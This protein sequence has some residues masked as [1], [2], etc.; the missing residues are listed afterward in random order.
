MDDRAFLILRRWPHHATHSGY[1]I[2]ARHV[3]TPLSADPIPKWLLPDRLLW[4]LARGVIPYD[5][6]AVALELLGARHMLTHRDAVYHFLYAESSYKYLG[7]LNGKRGHHLL[8]TFHVPPGGF[9]EIIQTSEHIKRLSGAII[10]GRNQYAMLDHALPPERIWFVPYAVD[11]EYFRP[12]DKHDA[13]T[14]VPN[15][16]TTR[17]ESTVLFVGHHLRDF[18]VLRAVIEQAGLVAPQLKFVVVTLP[19]CF[20]HFANLKG[21]FELYSGLP[22]A[23]LLRLYQQ[24]ILMAL[25]LTDAVANTA[26]LEAMACG[27]PMVITDV[28]AVRDYVDESHAL[29]VPK[30][31]PGAML[32]AILQLYAARDARERMGKSARQRA[33]LFDWHIIADQVRRIYQS[34][35]G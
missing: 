31:E 3:G 21:N 6:T 18:Q 16:P 22:E 28:G 35:R 11:T 1:D 17:E 10:L 5:R 14:G 4:R 25:P 9:V 13:P 30:G 15:A 2:L 23:E 29:L 12:L 33:L 27:L 19:Y 26:V 34:L 20:S 7:L 32:D 24:A 8:A